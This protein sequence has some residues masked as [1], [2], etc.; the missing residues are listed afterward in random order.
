M[1]RRRRLNTLMDLET[2]LLKEAFKGIVDNSGA[3]S[4][5]CDVEC[6]RYVDIRLFGR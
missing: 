5:S 4:L 3:I 6:G 1:V 2:L